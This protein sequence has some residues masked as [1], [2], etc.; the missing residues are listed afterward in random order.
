MPWRLLLFRFRRTTG[1]PSGFPAWCEATE[2]VTAPH[3]GTECWAGFPLAE[4]AAERFGGPA[5]LVNDAEMQG[6][7]VI[8][9]KGLELVLTLG[10]GAGTG[11]FRNGALMP[12]LE[13]AHHPIH[14]K[15]TYNGYIGNDA[16]EKAGKKHWNK[17]V[18]RTIDILSA[19]LHFDHLFIGGGNA[20]K[21]SI[22]TRRWMTI[23]PNDAGI[24]GGAAL[25]RLPESIFRMTSGGNMAAAQRLAQAAPV[26]PK[27]SEFFLAGDAFLLDIDGTLLDIAA[28]P[29]A[30]HAPDALKRTLARLQELTSGA[31]ALVSGRSLVSIDQLFSPLAI[32]AIGCHGAE[33][34]K[35]PGEKLER[36]A[37][38]LSA[39]LKDALCGTV[40]DLSGVRIENKNYTLAFHYRSAPCV[41]IHFGSAPCQ[42][43]RSTR[44]RSLPAARQVRFRGEAL[45]LRQR[46]SHSRCS[47]AFRLS[48]TAARFSSVT[49]EPTN[50]LSLSF[51]R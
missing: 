34:R 16:L 9:G 35:N 27:T 1:L 23:V 18:A 41:Q 32:A 40:A 8:G 30:V 11:V 25:W 44:R 12:H 28:T 33:W 7:A 47:W 36:R 38:P 39:G 20:R 29:E 46:R 5:R 3:F 15:K 2:I 21:L 43:H 45:C 22:A 17:R 48:P 4:A 42:C 50:M 6:L 49:T 37:Q 19:L 14:G 24:E 26:L 13:L 10:T 31:V 51:G